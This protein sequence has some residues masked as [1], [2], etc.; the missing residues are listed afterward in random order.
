MVVSI[1]PIAHDDRT[2]WGSLWMAYLDFYETA[3]T[4][5]Q[6]HRTFDR[7]CG[8]EGPLHG[9]VATID[10]RVVGIVHCLFHPS[11]WTETDY[12]Y[13]QDLYVSPDHRGGGIGRRLIEA[14]VTC[15]RA[16]GANRVYWLTQDNNA[17]AR[18][19]YDRVARQTGLIQYRIS[20]LA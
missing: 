6:V 5:A 15:A 17:T 14:V 11:T 20:P 12:C 3:M 4:D 8:A 16:Y 10:G 19:L 18:I 13:L 7:L 2:A 9:F 1:R